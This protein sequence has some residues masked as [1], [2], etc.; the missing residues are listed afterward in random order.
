MRRDVFDEVTAHDSDA[1]FVG[2]GPRELHYV[3]HDVYPRKR[4]E[5][6]SNIIGSLLVGSA[7]NVQVYSPPVA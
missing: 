1:A 6:E 5:I 7:T 2:Q 4:S 3:M